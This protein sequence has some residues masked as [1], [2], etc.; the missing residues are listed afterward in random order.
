MATRIAKS[1]IVDVD[2]KTT[3]IH[4]DVARYFDNADGSLTLMR[5]TNEPAFARYTSVIGFSILK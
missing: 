3:H 5:G 2:S 1:V 4:H